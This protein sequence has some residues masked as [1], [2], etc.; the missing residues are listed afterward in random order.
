MSPLDIPVGLAAIALGVLWAVAQVIR[1]VAPRAR[2]IR[3]RMRDTDRLLDQ[4]NAPT[5]WDGKR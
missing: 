1:W 4:L 5:L 2:T 3:R